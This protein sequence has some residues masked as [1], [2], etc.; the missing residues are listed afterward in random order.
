MMKMKYITVLMLGLVV[1]DTFAKEV[2]VV[3]PKVQ[4]NVA[5]LKSI[6]S[7]I[8]TFHASFKQ[9]VIDAQGE[10]VQESVGELIL[11]QPNLMIWQVNEPDENLMVADGSTLWYSDPFVEQVIAVDQAASVANNPIVLLSDPENKSWQD[12]NIDFGQGMYKVKAISP[13]SQ[14][15]ELQLRFEQGK[16][17]ELSLIDRQLQISKLVFSDIQQNIPLGNEPFKFVVPDGFELDDQ[18]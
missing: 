14:I 1:T 2:P 5:E 12:F 3:E 10:Q 11:K 13:Q 4:Q 6:L 18:R 15:A 17:V 7:S 8:R 16:L 9:T